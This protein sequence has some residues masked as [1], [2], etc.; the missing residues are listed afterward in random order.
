MN[1]AAIAAADGIR[2]ADTNRTHNRKKSHR[3]VQHLFAFYI[4]KQH[5]R[6]STFQGKAYCR[7]LNVVT[8]NIVTKL[9]IV[10]VLCQS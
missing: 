5:L 9:L 6:M 1:D 2:A 10:K 3:V 7:C 4:I 8:T